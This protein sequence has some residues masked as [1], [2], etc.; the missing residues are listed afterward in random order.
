MS[1]TITV[2]RT[3]NGSDMANS[4]EYHETLDATRRYMRETYGAKGPMELDKDGR[5]EGFADPD[6][7][8]NLGAYDIYIERREITLTRTGICNA[9]KNIPHR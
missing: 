3:W 5:W 6:V 8:T 1:R 7:A 2:Y 4:D 9:L